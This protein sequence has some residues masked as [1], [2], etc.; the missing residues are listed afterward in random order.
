MTSLETKV[1][2]RIATCLK[3]FDTY[4]IYKTINKAIDES[5]IED[6]E[7]CRSII[8]AYQESMQYQSKKLSEAQSWLIE[9]LN[10]K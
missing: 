10:N 4:E 6:K 7:S 9:L 3:E 8:T 1:I 5:G 2:E